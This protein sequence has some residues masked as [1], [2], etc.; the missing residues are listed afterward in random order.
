MFPKR[1]AALTLFAAIGIGSVRAGTLSIAPGK[2]DISLGQTVD[3][4]VSLDS[5]D[6]T[7]TPHDSLIL[8]T[9]NL[10]ASGPAAVNVTHFRL[11]PSLPSGSFLNYGDPTSGSAIMLL[12]SN[13]FSS[14][15]GPLYEFDFTPTAPGTYS[16]DAAGGVGA[17]GSDGKDQF[18]PG[19]T[20][21]VLVTAQVVSEPTGLSLVTVG[22][23]GFAVRRWRL[24]SLLGVANNGPRLLHR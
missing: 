7:P 4:T 5:T 24:R 9:T 23:A 11:D 13:D 21:T 18:S 17:Y 15:D 8:V 10:G 22:L 12:G 14:F 1:L 19:N 3:F 16:F 20:A 6:P 2:S